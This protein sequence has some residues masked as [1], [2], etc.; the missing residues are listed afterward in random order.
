MIYWVIY[1]HPSDYPDKYVARKWVMSAG[2][3]V[4]TS[5]VKLAD[6]LAPLRLEM[7]RLGLI[8]FARWEDD[9]RPIVETWM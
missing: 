1:R 9:E 5:E 3:C 8:P 4:P 7:T 2:K 6:E